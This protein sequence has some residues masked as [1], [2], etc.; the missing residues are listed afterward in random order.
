VTTV[1]LPASA[2]PIA[3][4][5]LG[6]PVWL[7]RHAPTS[8]T[9]LRW[10]GRADPPLS[11]EGH[12]AAR[13]LAMVVAGT[14]DAVDGAIVR[15]SPARRARATADE[16]SLTTGLPIVEDAELLEVDVGAAE[17]LIWTVLADRYPE[18]AASLA[19]GKLVD[20]PG[21]ETASALVE[22][23]ARAAAQIRRD[24]R[25]GHVVVVSHGVLLNA[26]VGALVGPAAAWTNQPDTSPAFLAP[27]GILRLVP[28]GRR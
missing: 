1:A 22:R 3:I 15:S 8:W 19:D 20:W 26:L 21:G 4:A 28:E 9:G 25:H 27:G 17:G 7:I 11:T 5:R 2:G 14:L 10:C 24:A 18:L 23:A 12:E 6:H 13:R 16:I